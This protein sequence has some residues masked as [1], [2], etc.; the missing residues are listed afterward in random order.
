M[1]SCT[2][3]D[4]LIVAEVI[5]QTN[6]IVGVFLYYREKGAE[7]FQTTD[8][9]R[10]TGDS[11]QA[12]IP[13][14]FITE[15]GTEYFIEA[16]DDYEVSATTPVIEI[17]QQ[18]E[19]VLT[20]P[21]TNMLPVNGTQNL[22]IPI[23]FSW[24]GSPDALTHDLYLWPAN[25]ERPENPVL[26]G[27]TEQGTIY[28]PQ[29][30]Q[31]GTDYSWQIISRD[32]CTT[33]AG[34]VQTITFRQLPDLV[35]SSVKAPASAFSEETIE[36]EWEVLNTGNGSTGDRQW[37]DGIYLSASPVFDV[38]EA[39]YLK[40][41]P[42]ASTLVTNEGYTLTTTVTLPR[43]ITGEYYFHVET[44]RGA[45]ILEST[46]E[47]NLSVQNDPLQVT[48]KPPPDLEV[49]SVVAPRNS[50]SEQTLAIRWQVENTGP[51]STEVTA[52][53]DGIYLSMDEELDIGSA[54]LLKSI[55]FEGELMPG[56]SYTRNDSVTLPGGIQGI[57]Y[58]FVRTNTGNDV[59]EI[60]ENNTR[61]SDS[62]SVVLLPFPDLVTTEVTARDSANSNESISISWEVQNQGARII[63]STSWV[64]RI[65][66]STSE[67]GS[68]NII[69]LA[70][71]QT[72]LRLD[73]DQA[74]QGQASVTIP[75]NITGSW[76]IFV[77][78]DASNRVM[79]FDGERNNIDR[80]ETPIHIA[81]P[82]L[83]VENIVLPEGAASG[84]RLTL[85]WRVGNHG[86]GALINRSWRD[87]I[88]LSP[89]S[90]LGDDA[91][92]LAAANTHSSLVPGSGLDKS[93]Q[94]LIP[95]GM[96]G[97]YYI[98]IATD[99]GNQIFED[100]QEENN[101]R[102]S[103]TP[104][105]ITLS[106][107]AD[108]LVNPF[109][110]PDSIYA[111]TPF[112]LNITV[113]NQGQANAD[114]TLWQDQIYVSL[115]SVWN[116]S[117]AKFLSTI[118]RSQGLSS[119]ASYAVQTSVTIPMLSLLEPGL[120]RANCYI[121][122]KTDAL[123]DVYEHTDED[124]N[125]T[126]SSPIVVTC[127]GP[128]NLR[129][130]QVSANKSSLASGES[131][132]ASWR[133]TNTGSKTTFWDYQLWYDGI[134]L[135]TD[136]IW[137]AQDIFVTDQVIPGPLLEGESYQASLD[138]RMP[139]GF[140]GQYYVLIV[141]DHTNKNDEGDFSDNYQYVRVTNEQ[142]EPLPPEIPFTILLIW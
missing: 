61:R 84:Q 44:D 107:F 114:G 5:D 62:L 105:T 113:S 45:N 23:R 83:T 56:E 42:N 50:F 74:Y 97:S 16:F 47:N 58:L 81:T 75:N 12:Y 100:G 26:V 121:H 20:T 43:G 141:A 99:Q 18:A 142:G 119:N 48:L 68:E 70:G 122:V 1:L 136:T 133:V 85:Q 140:S 22:N 128:V 53:T 40:G 96:E 11:F 117:T 25:Q 131:M 51:G 35:V 91:I 8:M 59:Y 71:Q 139:D 108:L 17:T 86:Q 137:D 90:A 101:T 79:E 127:P 72:N 57:W 60:L 123:N 34:P 55:P 109:T 87:V 49:S 9:L 19:P 77:E 78:T 38:D 24:A 94:V 82:D 13:S 89:T 41:I 88:Y 95:Q 46:E 98:I 111:G 2:G 132:T 115:D 124:N 134:Y 103:N 28:R 116:P 29:N 21:V 65:F 27:I 76:Y 10:K 93:L 130:D 14:A 125:I 138:F 104:L 3:V 112:D 118:T 39:L 15:T 102:A 31:Y 36:L 6:R 69:D 73:L 80:N 135:S 37:Y 7:E 129:M 67:D 4:A 52:W 64:D 66:L 63:E 32:A 54:S 120:K 106:P 33:L 126:R 110:V 30:V 92:E